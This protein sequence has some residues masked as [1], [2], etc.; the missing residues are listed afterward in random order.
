MNVFDLA[1]LLVLAIFGAIGALRGLVRTVFFLVTWLVASGVA[2]FFAAPVANALEGTIGEPVVRTL[3]AFVLIFLVVLFLGMAATSVL[4]RIMESM[5]ILKASN[6]LLG[7]LVGVGLGVVVVV[8]AFLLA[9]LT[10]LPHGNWWRHS[11]LA[12]FFESLA[13]FASEFLPSDIARHIRYS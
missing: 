4:H 9:G 8:V 3:A 13:V 11:S 1:L 12:P 6:R 2:W 7:G 10:S 5:P